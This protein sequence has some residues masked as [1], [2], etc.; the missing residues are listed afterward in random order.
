MKPVSRFAELA[1]G[2]AVA[3]KGPGPALGDLEP[4]D[5]LWRAYAQEEEQ[6]HNERPF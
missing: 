1:A 5:D 6:A 4:F 3:I 2:S